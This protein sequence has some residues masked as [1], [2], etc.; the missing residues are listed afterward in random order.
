MGMKVGDISRMT[1]KAQA[2]IYTK[3][4]WLKLE[5][6]IQRLVHEG[7]LS[8]QR[9][10]CKALRDIQD[11]RARV[12]LAVKA[13]ERKLSAKT[14]VTAASALARGKEK[15]YG[16]TPALEEVRERRGGRPVDEMKWDAMAQ[17]GVMP[18][19]PAVRLAAIR[20]CEGCLLASAASREV[21]KECPAPQ[22]LLL[23][24]EVVEGAR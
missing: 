19:W 5:P 1:G 11:S 22:M 9:E 12:E 10:V 14:I 23:L 20:T 6:E 24:A 18:P 3:M 21:C 4:D 16:G 17:A 8:G 2:V 7:K 15:R 13:A